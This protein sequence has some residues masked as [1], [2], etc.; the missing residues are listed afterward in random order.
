MIASSVNVI[1]AV[2]LDPF[3][4][5]ND[6]DRAQ[7][8]AAGISLETVRTLGELTLA[9]RR[10]HMLVIRL[11][12]SAELLQEVQTLIGQLGNTVPVLCRVDR[13]RMEVAV[14]AMRLGAL[15][16]LPADEWTP[17]VW[18]EAV[19][20]LNSPELT[21]KSYVFVDPTSQ[22]LLAL[23]QRVAQTEVTALLVGPTGAG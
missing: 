4:P 12:D 21:T 14:D 18:Q 6:A 23:A 9:L 1:H 8:D 19:Q 17:A 10:A 11:G 20:G 13:R 5:I 16:V 22:H 3:S 2:W 15:H 7:L